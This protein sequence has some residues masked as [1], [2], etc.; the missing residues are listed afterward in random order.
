ML[1]M[2]RAS[3]IE[4]KCLDAIVET[5]VIATKLQLIQFTDE[6]LGVKS[7]FH[8]SAYIAF[9]PMIDTHLAKKTFKEL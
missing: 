7:F 2:F 9:S 3:T 5:V 4:K 6:F 1:R 8:S